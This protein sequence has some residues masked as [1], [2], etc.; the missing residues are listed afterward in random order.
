[1]THRCNGNANNHCY[2][3]HCL[4]SQSRVPDV[5]PTDHRDDSAGVCKYDCARYTTVDVKFANATAG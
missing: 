4:L 1:M 5:V 2:T 3:S